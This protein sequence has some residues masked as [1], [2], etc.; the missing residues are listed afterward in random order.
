[1]VSALRCLEFLGVL[2]LLL[3]RDFRPWLLSVERRFLRIFLSFDLLLLLLLLR[4]LDCDLLFDLDLLLLLLILDCFSGGDSLLDFSLGGVEFSLLCF[5]GSPTLTVTGNG[6]SDKGK[7]M[8]TCSIT[9]TPFGDS[10]LTGELDEEDDLEDAFED[11]FE[12]E[13]VDEDEEELDEEF[14]RDRELELDA[15]DDLDLLGFLAS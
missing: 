6:I 5:F 2:L 4:D 11:A 3:L 9:G 7:G 12:M 14:D 13:D 15:E 10:A 8:S 1:M